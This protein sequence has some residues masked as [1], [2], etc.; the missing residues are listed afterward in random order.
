MVK[1]YL[2]LCGYYRQ[3]AISTEVHMDALFNLHRYAK[4]PGDSIERVMFQIHNRVS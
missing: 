4:I 2:D 3:V 1:E